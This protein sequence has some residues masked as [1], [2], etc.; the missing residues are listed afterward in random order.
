M[1]LPGGAL[2]IA[3]GLLLLWLAT[4]GRLDRLAAIWPFLTGATDVPGG[5]A[6]SGLAGGAPS[7]IAS[8]A[9]PTTFHAGEM[10]A[11]LTPTVATV[12]VS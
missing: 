6:S 7:G 3:V 11:A 12:L 5:V 2:L 8:L 10:I 4:T 1:R 9:N